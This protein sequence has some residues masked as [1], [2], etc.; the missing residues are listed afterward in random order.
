MDDRNIQV[1]RYW[2]R[3]AEC[4]PFELLKIPDN[5]E[6]CCPHCFYD[7]ASLLRVEFRPT[8]ELC[9]IEVGAFEQCTNLESVVL[10]PSLMRIG[11]S[12]FG[13]CG[14]L[15]SVSFPAGSKL[16]EIGSSAFRVCARLTSIT[17]ASSVESLG[18]WCFSYCKKLAAV[19]FASV[20]SLT[21]LLPG[22]AYGNALRFRVSRLPLHLMFGSCAEWCA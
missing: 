4:P 21:R 8:S 13:W 7:S 5:I 9:L 2:S 16:K 12:A 19:D 22:V 17:I 3:A 18:A 20:E 1:V 6:V 11:D 10:P 14:T 15:R